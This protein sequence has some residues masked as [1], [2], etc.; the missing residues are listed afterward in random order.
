MSLLYG[1]RRFRSKAVF[2]KSAP[3]II[4][5][6]RRCASSLTAGGSELIG[7]CGNEGESQVVVEPKTIHGCVLVEIVPR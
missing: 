1:H 2:T 7:C 5:G 4:E 3:L 6:P